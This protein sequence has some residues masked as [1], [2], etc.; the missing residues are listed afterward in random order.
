[1][2]VSDARREAN[3]RNALKSTGPRTPEG[4]EKSRRNALTHGLTALVVA[5]EDPAAFQERA[6]DYFWSL[7]PR[8]KF[9][10]YLVDEVALI[11]IR[12]E[13]AQRIERKLR[14]KV[15]LRAITS[16]D[17]DRGLEAERLGR[18]LAARP[19][20][21]VAELRRTPR[22]CDWLVGRWAMLAN[23]ADAGDRWPDD[24][25]RLAF[26][27][28]ATP[29]EFRLGNPGATVD[30]DGRTLDDGEDRAAVARAQIASI[31]LDREAAAEHDEVDRALAEADLSD[32]PT[33]E[34][35]RL[36]RYEAALHK[37]LRWCMARLND[38]I[39]THR[40][41]FDLIP[42]HDPEAETEAEAEPE[43][44][45][46]ASRPPD[47]EPAAIGDPAGARNEAIVEARNEAIPEAEPGSSPIFPV[48]AGDRR[49]ARSRQ[50]EARREARKRKL[51]RRRA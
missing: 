5:A 27:L 48:V 49:D 9:Q 33:P 19:S 21:V 42:N 3:R 46:P 25:R 37:R 51:D 26:D 15:A 39:P 31:R 1:M 7:K 44:E 20:E 50:A 40:P 45:A 35:R 13:R 18:D 17:D 22:G 32:E 16:W 6:S 34:I 24:R 36:R 12:T 23:V 30:T 29:P 2:I 4:K 14:E 38:P 8:T 43:V 11:T 10:A 28:L 41:P 47:P